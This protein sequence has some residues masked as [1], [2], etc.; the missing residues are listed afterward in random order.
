MKTLWI[1]N[2]LCHW[3]RREKRPWSQVAWSLHGNSQWQRRAKT[4]VTQKMSK[5]L[6]SDVTAMYLVCAKQCQVE[7][8]SRSGELVSSARNAGPLVTVGSCF[9]SSC[10]KNIYCEGLLKCYK[11]R[12]L[13]FLTLQCWI[14]CGRKL[15]RALGCMCWFQSKSRSAKWHLQN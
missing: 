10:Q 9:V 11:S 5:L 12:K 3:R 15:E 7:R 4:G 8:A 13:S 2:V 14:T 6:E 1:E